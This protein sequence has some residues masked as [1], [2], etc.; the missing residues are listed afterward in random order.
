MIVSGSVG[1]PDAMAHVS[2][3]TKR[4][5]TM[6]EYVPF[7]RRWGRHWR[8]TRSN[9][10][11]ILIEQRQKD[12]S[13]FI[14][15]AYRTAIETNLASFNKENAEVKEVVANMLDTLDALTLRVNRLELCVV[16]ILDTLKDE[17]DGQ[18]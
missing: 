2:F 3:L 9:P 8:K 5:E 1:S 18:S 17:A 10:E 12:L 6:S 4:G 13:N 11:K 14:P 15:I 16:K 7:Y